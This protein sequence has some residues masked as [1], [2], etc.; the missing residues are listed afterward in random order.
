MNGF[1]LGSTVIDQN[2]H[3]TFDRVIGAGY[4]IQFLVEQEVEP[5]RDLQVQVMHQ[6]KVVATASFTDDGESAHCQ[7]VVVM[8]EHHRKGIATAVYVFA[9][10]L[11]RR[12]LYNFWKGD[13][14]QTAAAKALWAQPNRPFG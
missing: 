13:P 12:K 6:G 4:V 1:E 2:P 11:F 3:P 9:E 10:R 7:N 14:V 5:F 8:P